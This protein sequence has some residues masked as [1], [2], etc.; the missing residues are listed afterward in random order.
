MAVY[1]IAGEAGS[2]AFAECEYI[3]HKLQVSAPSVTVHLI[4]KHES[5]W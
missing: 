1:V 4:C 5:E 3:G 2:E